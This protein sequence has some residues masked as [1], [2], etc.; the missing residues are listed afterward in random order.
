MKKLIVLALVLFATSFLA[1]SVNAEGEETTTTAET[2]L[3]EETTTTASDEE[4][5]GII[6]EQLNAIEAVFVSLFGGL[7]GSGSLG[8][9]L[10]WLLKKKKKAADLAIDTLR[11]QNKITAEQADKYKLIAEQA[12]NFAT[13]GIATL[14]AKYDELKVSNEA[15]NGN[16]ETLLADYKAR[17]ERLS[18]LLVDKLA[19]SELNDGTD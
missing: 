17:D 9:V 19:G 8:L 6:E 18:A 4:I 16:V 13:I 14:Q 15:L 3:T 1:F 7:L 12:I 10:N 11:S 5:V 2:E